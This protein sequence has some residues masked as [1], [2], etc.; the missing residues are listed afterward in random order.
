MIIF[1]KHFCCDTDLR[2]GGFRRICC[3]CVIKHLTLNSLGWRRQKKRTACSTAHLT[4]RTVHIAFDQLVLLA[5]QECKSVKKTRKKH[6]DLNAWG[7]I[8]HGAKARKAH[9][10]PQGRDLSCAHAGADLQAPVWQ[11]TQ[12]SFGKVCRCLSR[13]V[14]SGGYIYETVVCKSID[15]EKLQM[16]SRLHCWRHFWMSW[17]IRVILP[18][19]EM[20]GSSK[21]KIPQKSMEFTFCCQID[22]SMNVIAPN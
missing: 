6:D 16:S 10:L 8:I 15:L 3:T 12:P 9:F 18:T 19:F 13:N 20:V 11:E 14:S 5:F 21:G 1:L 22:F 4:D 7:M 17:Y 2:L